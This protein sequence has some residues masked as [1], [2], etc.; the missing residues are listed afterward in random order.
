[1]KKSIVPK[2]CRQQQA[3]LS[4]HY[5]RAIM[6][7]LVAGLI[8]GAAI[9]PSNAFADA[10]PQV[11]GKTIGEWSAKWWRWAFAIPAS[12]NPMLDDDG[13]FCPVGQQGPVWFLAG[14]WGEA[15]P[16]APVLFQEESISCFQLLTLSGFKLRPIPMG[17]RKLI[18]V[19]RRTIIYFS[20]LGISRLWPLLME[21]RLSLIPKLP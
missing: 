2:A 13:E 8:A 3:I 18:I 19:N 7:M 6:H 5:T 16:N 20:Y 10:E 12:T 14:V 11:L 17:I 21:S 1:M 4:K 15:R 9:A